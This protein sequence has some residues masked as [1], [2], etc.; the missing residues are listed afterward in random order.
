[1][2]ILFVDDTVQSGATLK[3]VHGLTAHPDILNRQV[4]THV[5]QQN[6]DTEDEQGHNNSEQ[7]LRVGPVKH[8]LQHLKFVRTEEESMEEGQ[9]GAFESLIPLPVV[10]IYFRPLILSISKKA[11]IL[12]VF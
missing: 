9:N 8:F 4:H 2:K 5:H 12:T 7:V 10:I 3:A 1:M 11:Y 6:A